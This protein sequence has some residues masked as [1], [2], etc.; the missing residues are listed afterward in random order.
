MWTFD[1]K[2]WF[3][4]G[5]GTK[6]EPLTVRDQGSRFLLWVLPLAQRSDAEVRR[7]C[8]HLFQTYGCPKT[9][10]TDKGGPFRGNGPYGL[11]SL[12]LWWYRLGI[13]VEFVGRG[14]GIDNNAHEQM[15]GVM[16]KETASPPA[17]TYQAQL[18]RLRRWQH[19][20]NHER[21]HDGIGQKPPCRRYRPQPSPLP[22]L[23][24][25]VYPNGWLVRT[26]RLNGDIHLAGKRHYIGRTFAGLPVGCKR[27]AGGYHVYFHRLVLVSIASQH[28]SSH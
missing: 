25:P 12:S 9:I 21:P 17:K 13:E 24:V 16:K 5:D 1:W 26:V 22:P 23:L 7:V 4:S 28:L 19:C 14:H 11:T 6:I 27:T 18:C 8:R 3:R 2:G 15:H 20:Y 10:R